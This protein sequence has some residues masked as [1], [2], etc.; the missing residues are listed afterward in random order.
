[1]LVRDREGRPLGF[2]GVRSD[3]T[4]HKVREELLRE[5][6]EFLESVVEGVQAGVCVLDGTMRCLYTNH[7]FEK[8]TGIQRLQV[9][10]G[11]TKLAIHSEDLDRTA[12][13]VLEAVAGRAARC[14]SRLCAA[15]GAMIEVELLMTPLKWKGLRLALALVLEHSSDAEPPIQRS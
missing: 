1:M 15:D 3:I 11:R 8:M 14:R 13:S 10:A 9:V 5:S 7:R 4:S 6:D 12:I 2:Q